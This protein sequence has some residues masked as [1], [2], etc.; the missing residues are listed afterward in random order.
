MKLLSW[1][2]AINV[3]VATGFSLAGLLAPQ[4]ILPPGSLSTQASQI[5][6]MYAAARTI[7]L[8]LA[9]LIV[10]WKKLSPALF[11]LAGLAG[12]IQFMDAIIGLYQHDVGKTAG[13]FVIGLL[14]FY[15]LFRACKL[16]KDA[17]L[18]AHSTNRRSPLSSG[19]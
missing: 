13:P 18:T 6:A 4:S 12:L 3:L 7:P 19:T 8:A 11:V 5:F 9:T 1:I 14:Q 2:T 17:I 10:I 16:A 15:A